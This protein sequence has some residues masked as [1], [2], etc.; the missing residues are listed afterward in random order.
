MKEKRTSFPTSVR[1]GE[2]ERELL[3]AL[4]EHFE[5][6]SISKVSEN[7]V[8]KLA[9]RELAERNGIQLKFRSKN[10][11]T[12]EATYHET[13]EQAV[14]ASLTEHCQAA[15]VKVQ[16]QQEDGSWSQTTEDF[17]EA[18]KALLGLSLTDKLKRAGRLPE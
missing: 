17:E 16:S 6:T 3:K 2:E 15:I 5:E 7:D 14:D 8:I 4:I 13:R 12:G 18:Y 9:I 10:L 1:L 11:V